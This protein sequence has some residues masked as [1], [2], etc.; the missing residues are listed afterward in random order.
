[1]A[2]EEKSA[3]GK[4]RSLVEVENE[5]GSYETPIIATYKLTNIFPLEIKA[6]SATRVLGRKLS[7]VFRFFR[8]A[9][10]KLRTCAASEEILMYTSKSI[11]LWFSYTRV[12]RCHLDRIQIVTHLRRSENKSRFCFSRNSRF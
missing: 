7:N 2:I 1:M 3:G 5:Y 11:L 12:S 6:R 10:S 4:L 9:E 8:I